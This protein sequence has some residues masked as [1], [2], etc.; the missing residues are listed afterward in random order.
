MVLP[1]SAVSPARMWH[2]SNKS[3]PPTGPGTMVL[4]SARRPEPLMEYA[5]KHAF[6]NLKAET[7]D[8]LAKY[9]YDLRTD[10]DFPTRLFLLVQTVL[11][12]TVEEACAYLE[13][14]TFSTDIASEMEAALLTEEMTDAMTANDAKEVDKLLEQ[15]GKVGV[16]HDQFKMLLRGK[17]ATAKTGGKRKAIVFLG[18]VGKFDALDLSFFFA[19]GPGPDLARPVQCVLVR[20]LRWLSVDLQ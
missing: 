7:I 9:E 1:T 14:R 3:L 2:L 16:V 6:W 10:G 17:R 15:T 12:C 5:A 20:S 11:G 8:R 19:S 13:A 18:E 4:Q